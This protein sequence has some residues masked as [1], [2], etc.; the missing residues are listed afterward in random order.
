MSA[1][2]G[3]NNSNTNENSTATAANS[4]S[5]NVSTSDNSEQRQINVV[6]QSQ[7]Q[8]EMMKTVADMA[9]NVSSTLAQLPERVADAVKEMN[10]TPQESQQAT[11]Q[12]T[13][14]A[15]E[16]NTGNSAPTTQ[17][18][19]PEKPNVPQSQGQPSQSAARKSFS[20]W[21]FSK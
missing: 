14:Q 15:Q 11:Q 4:G 8:S 12:A 9:Q 16:Q 7:E 21:W 3:E 2:N 1:P 13:Q 18:A 6:R 20:D 17:T 5:S 10:P 19:Q